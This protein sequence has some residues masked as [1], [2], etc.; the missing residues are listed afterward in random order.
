[1]MNAEFEWS[2]SLSRHRADVQAIIAV[3]IGGGF[4]VLETVV[5]NDLWNSDSSEYFADPDDLFYEGDEPP[6]EPGLYRFTGYTSTLH[7]DEWNHHGS[8]EKLPLN[9]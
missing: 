1:M 5:G 8:Y 9:Q 2:D 6:K 3:G 4:A 7:G